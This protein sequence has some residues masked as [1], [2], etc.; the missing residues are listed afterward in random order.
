MKPFLHWQR[1][2]VWLAV[3]VAGAAAPRALAAAPTN[4]PVALTAAQFLDLYNDLYQRLYAVSQEAAWKASTDVTD[5]HTG[6]RIRSFPR[7]LL[8]GTTT[9]STA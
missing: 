9:I 2:L 7:A 4:A 6:Q 1:I 3:C 8:P 5:E